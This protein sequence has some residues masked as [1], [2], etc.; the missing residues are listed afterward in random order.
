MIMTET[1]QDFRTRLDNILASW[2]PQDVW[3]QVNEIVDD[4]EEQKWNDGWNSCWQQVR[5]GGATG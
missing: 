2:L 5:N 1:N 3:N 4:I